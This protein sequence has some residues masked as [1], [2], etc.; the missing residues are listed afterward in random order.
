MSFLKNKKFFMILITLLMTL[1]FSVSFAGVIARN[2]VDEAD[3]WWFGTSIGMRIKF[4]SVKGGEEYID[5]YTDN[6]LNEPAILTPSMIKEFIKNDL[7]NNSYTDP[8]TEH[9]YKFCLGNWDEFVATYKWDFVDIDYITPLT[10]CEQIDGVSVKFSSTWGNPECKLSSGHR[11]NVSGIFDGD[12][13]TAEDKMRYIRDGLNNQGW[14]TG[15]RIELYTDLNFTERYW[16][17]IG[18][19]DVDANGDWENKSKEFSGGLYYSGTFVGNGYSITYQSIY[20]SGL[21]HSGSNGS[22]RPLGFFAYTKNAIITNLIL[23]D[24]KIDW[25]ANTS[26]RVV[27]YAG[28]LI[29]LASQTTISNVVVIDGYINMQDSYATGS[30]SVGG[31]I[32][33][34]TH[35]EHMLTE[36]RP[37]LDVQGVRYSTFTNV[38]VQATVISGSGSSSASGI[39]TTDFCNAGGIIGTIH[40]RNSTAN[41]LGIN[42]TDCMFV[43]DIILEP[44]TYAY[45]LTLGGLIGAE[46]LINNNNIEPTVNITKCAVHLGKE[47]LKT[48]TQFNSDNC[49]RRMYHAFWPGVVNFPSFTKAGMAYRWF[50]YD[51]NGEPIIQEN[52]VLSGSYNLTHGSHFTIT[53][54]Y[55]YT[56]YTNL[57]WSNKVYNNYSAGVNPYEVP[58]DGQYCTDC[59]GLTSDGVDASRLKTREGFINIYR[60]GALLGWSISEQ[61][62]KDVTTTW[63]MPRTDEVNNGLPVPRSLVRWGTYT[64]VNDSEYKFSGYQTSED[65]WVELVED[66]EHTTGDTTTIIIPTNLGTINIEQGTNYYTFYGYKLDATPLASFP[67][68][69]IYWKKKG[70]NLVAS[71]KA[72]PV[73]VT[74]KIIDISEEFL[75]IKPKA[76]FNDYNLSI[77]GKEHSRYYVIEDLAYNTAIYNFDRNKFSSYVSVDNG[78]VMIMPS[79]SKYYEVYSL[80]IYEWENGTEPKCDY[81]AGVVY[82]KKYHYVTSNTTIVWYVKLKTSTYSISTHSNQLDENGDVISL[83]GTSIAP[84][85]KVYG[86]VS[87]NKDTNYQYVVGSTYSIEDGKL[88]II[89]P[90]NADGNPLLD[91]IVI[92]TTNV[93]GYEFIGYSGYGTIKVEVEENGETI[94][95]DTDAWVEYDTFTKFNPKIVAIF[96]QI[97]YNFSLNYDYQ[98]DYNLDGK[99]TS[100]DPTSNGKLIE[101]YTVESN[102]TY[103]DDMATQGRIISKTPAVEYWLNATDKT[104]ADWYIRLAQNSNGDKISVGINYKGYSGSGYAIAN[105]DSFEMNATTIYEYAAVYSDNSNMWF[106]IRQQLNDA[107]NEVVI[108]GE[109]ILEVYDTFTDL[110]G[111]YC[112]V[113]K[114]VNEGSY[115][116]FDA[117]IIRAKWANKY[118]VTMSNNPEDWKELTDIRYQLVGI[119]SEASLVNTTTGE[120]SIEQESY[121]EITLQLKSGSNYDYGFMSN[122]GDAFVKATSAEYN[123]FGDLHKVTSS[124]GSYAVYNYGHEIVGWKIS[125]QISTNNG[126]QTWFIYY[127]KDTKSW[128]KTNESSRYTPIADLIVDD[129][130]TDQATMLTLASYADELDNWFTSAG[131]DFTVGEIR[132]I[133]VWEAVNITGVEYELYRSSYVITNSVLWNITFGGSFNT[134]AGAVKNKVTNYTTAYLDVLDS[135]AT[136]LTDNIVVFAKDSE[137]DWLYTNLT[138]DCYEYSGDRQYEIK[139][140]AHNIANINRIELVYN[141]SDFDGKDVEFTIDTYGD[142][143][144]INGDYSVTIDGA[145]INKKIYNVFDTFANKQYTKLTQYNSNDKTMSTISAY[146]EYLKAYVGGYESYI[147]DPIKNADTYDILRKLYKVETIVDGEVTTNYYIYL[148]EGQLVGKLPEFSVDYYTNIAWNTEGYNAGGFN[149]GKYFYAL[150]AYMGAT[151]DK[152]DAYNDKINLGL[153]TSAGYAREQVVDWSNKYSIKNYDE[154]I[155]SS[156]SNA[157]FTA[158]WYRKSYTVEM[159]TVESHILGQY[160]Y[161]MMTVE[162]AV[163]GGEEYYLAIYDYDENNAKYIMT[164]VSLTNKPSTSILDIELSEATADPIVVKAGCDLTFDIYDQSRDHSYDSF[165]GHKYIG[166]ALKHDNNAHVTYDVNAG[167]TIPTFTAD[168]IENTMDVEDNDNLIA[169][170][171]FAKIKYDLRI[172]MNDTNAGT[173]TYKNLATAVNKYSNIT[174][175]V[176][177]LTVGSTFTITY[178]ALVGYEYDEN[179]IIFVTTNGIEEKVFYIYSDSIVAENNLLLENG[180]ILHQVTFKIDGAWLRE[181]YYDNTNSEYSDYRVDN[182]KADTFMTPANYGMGV[183][184]INTDYI[185]FGYQ[186]KIFDSYNNTDVETVTI[187]NQESWNLVTEHNGV[188]GGISLSELFKQLSESDD[189]TKIADQ[190]GNIYVGYVS[191]SGNKYALML[192]YAFN[193]SKHNDKR[194][195]SLNYSF[196]LLENNKSSIEKTFA[197]NQETLSNMVKTSA[198][199]ILP[200]NS[201]YRTI[202]MVLEVREIVE[203]DLSIERDGNDTMVTTPNVIIGGSDTLKYTLTAPVGENNSAKV[204]GYQGQTISTVASYDV[205]HYTGFK[206]LYNNITSENK[207]QSVVL[208]YYDSNADQNIVELNSPVMKFVFTTKQLTPNYTFYVEDNNSNFT[209]YELGAEGYTKAP[210]ALSDILTSFNVTT[211]AG[212]NDPVYY[213]GHTL[214][215]D[216]TLDETYANKYTVQIKVNDTDTTYDI[217]T[218]SDKTYTDGGLNV[219]ITLDMYDNSKLQ[220]VYILEDSTTATPNDNF[221][222][223]EITT[224]PIDSVVSSENLSTGV[225]I[226]AGSNVIIDFNLNYGYAITGYTK[227]NNSFVPVDTQ[228]G[229]NE[230]Y[231]KITSSQLIINN[232]DTGSDSSNGHGGIYRIHVKKNEYI[233]QLIQNDTSNYKLSSTSIYVGKTITLKPIET[234]E[235][236]ELVSYT[237]YYNGIAQTIEHDES[238]VANFTITSEILSANPDGVVEFYV[239]I[240][241]KYRVAVN[242]YANEYANMANV[243]SSLELKNASTQRYIYF[244][245]GTEIDMIFTT[246]V[247]GKYSIAVSGLDADDITLQYT[248]RIEATLTL[249]RDYTIIVTVSPN[250]YNITSLEYHYNT[251]G[252]DAELAT[253]TITNPISTSID[254]NKNTIING[255]KKETSY[256]VLTGIV[257]TGN[258]LPDI[259]L[260][261]DKNGYSIDTIGGEK[262]ENETVTID[263][264]T[265][266][267]TITANGFEI[268]EI[269]NG[270]SVDKTV[271]KI[272]NGTE[273]YSISY[274]T[275]SDANIELYYTSLIEIKG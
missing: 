62:G 213:I 88:T 8:K 199:L 49:G 120:K 4:D 87:V 146:A 155:N 2:K 262:I 180:E 153:V 119:K 246:K 154:Y 255:I 46:Y 272:I 129:T 65:A 104:F 90:N 80:N 143:V 6:K 225:S 131:L 247:E 181:Y 228:I 103:N 174:Y 256:Y 171:D 52:Y 204:Y 33:A 3:S 194:M 56:S 21:G 98:E 26:E 149:R 97:K 183:I 224:Q 271:Y 263:D 211:N 15:N 7:K 164:Y 269:V 206:M 207:T 57:N 27:D 249:D 165:I 203:L 250:K 201:E 9:I 267:V 189:E 54:S 75:G 253:E 55:A 110:N 73:D 118:N 212:P 232:Y 141:T 229:D 195:H 91:D 72:E 40:E 150:T 123:D 234:K 226:F 156:T 135:E 44:D 248:Y 158:A 265:Y 200:N 99:F 145:T 45:V 124:A 24:C 172:K 128:Y 178:N 51:N 157:K 100:A 188:I 34:V 258:D 117:E 1:T 113:I 198:G 18:V 19:Y 83:L 94:E 159:Q 10:L 37:S 259:V 67:K 31:L 22:D 36:H 32:G 210:T 252:E 205:A 48:I 70:Y 14:F 239:T 79:L 5:I 58:V 85:D 136:I 112:A 142:Y 261:I 192:S 216:Y 242:Y 96:D 147:A 105:S 196:P 138:A 166:F 42:M 208:D 133:P 38:V 257:L 25:S 92:S 173:F 233:A 12:T 81:N 122:A 240:A 186:V 78:R 28:L 140:V 230:S 227:G 121:N 16:E 243:N 68:D 107:G 127:D 215:F 270:E 63:Y 60:E 93:K 151:G 266:A 275:N 163:L 231:I 241:P 108:T 222:S 197:I 161:V 74:F 106:I 95:V 202:Y 237:Y 221:G 61:P 160:G 193:P 175:D 152:L 170:V 169:V 47:S 214:E 20:S 101:T 244:S 111:A 191:T 217:Y 162:D 245:K 251:L 209:T 71:F 35:E 184:V 134:T 130:T 273:T 82:N 132:M 182:I 30:Q 236:E 41:Y 235:N 116:Y 139:V 66:G 223:M 268:V 115:G 50:G 187:D 84:N 264:K 17:P 125:F 39:N 64:T 144:L 114:G 109:L 77:Y 190:D 176:T 86:G 43:G 23:K 274:N 254:Y 76:S 148:A 218:I 238:G 53:D 69:N 179:A 29:G 13:Y 126:S 177:N 168:Y 219:Y 260:S 89:A 102:K 220:V 59:Y 167:Y 137:Y 185:D 11:A